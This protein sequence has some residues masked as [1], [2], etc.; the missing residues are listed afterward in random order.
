MRLIGF[1]L[2][3][4]AVASFMLPGLRPMLPFRVPVED[5]DATNGSLVLGLAGIVALIADR[6]R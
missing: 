6:V 1:L 2:L 3:A 5:W 4:L